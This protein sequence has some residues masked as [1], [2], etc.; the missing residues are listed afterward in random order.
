MASPELLTANLLHL[1][2]Q[3]VLDASLGEAGRRSVAV[4]VLR[5]LD[6]LIQSGQ[7]SQPLQQTCLSVAQV[8]RR[9]SGARDN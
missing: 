5:H 8:W 2:S 6:T 4:I 9:R 3:Y 1:M 7:L